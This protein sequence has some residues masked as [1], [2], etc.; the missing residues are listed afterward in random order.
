MEV[1][2]IVDPE[3]RVLAFEVSKGL[4]LDRRRVVKVVE[5]IHGVTITRR[6]KLI[7]SLDHEEF[8]E[9]TLDGA[10]FVAWEPFND[11]DRYWIGPKSHQW[12]EVIDRVRDAFLRA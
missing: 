9:F 7:E 12:T 6:P 4:T 2:D 10:E 11:S 1:S 3:K 8:C 5:A